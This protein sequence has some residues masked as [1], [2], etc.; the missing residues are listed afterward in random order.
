MLLFLIYQDLCLAGIWVCHVV[1]YL[2]SAYARVDG[3][4][5]GVA[6]W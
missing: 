1:V 2:F 4:E 6:A 5:V 3:G